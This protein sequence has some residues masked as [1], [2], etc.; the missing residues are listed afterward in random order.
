MRA[1]PDTG[2]AQLVGHLEQG[3]VPFDSGLFQMVLSPDGRWLAGPLMDGASSNIW[4]LPT[5]GGPMRPI[6]DFGGRAA[7]IVRRVSWSPDSRR[8]FA[9]VAETDADVVMFTGVL[10]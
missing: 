4:L 9:A 2:P 5:A 10:P 1:R 6:T 8:I 7:L 3:R